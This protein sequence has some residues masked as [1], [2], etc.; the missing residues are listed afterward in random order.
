MKPFVHFSSRENHKEHF[1]EII[2]NLD[3]WL[4]SRCRLNFLSGAVAANWWD[5]GVET[6]FNRRVYEIKG[7][8]VKN[9]IQVKNLP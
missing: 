6:V 3:Q 2:L 1:S 7:D 4:R 8:G 9:R 5:F